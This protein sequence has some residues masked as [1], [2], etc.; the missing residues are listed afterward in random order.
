MQN[1]LKNFMEAFPLSTFWDH[2]IV[3]NTWANPH[4]ESFQDY[5]SEN[6]GTFL[7]KIL[8]CNN[9]IKIMAEKNITV[10]IK[11]K[12]YYVCSKKVKKYPEIAEEFNKIKNDIRTNSLMFKDIKVS[13]ILER[14]RES[15]KNEGFYIVT[16]YRTT[17]CID[18]KN[19]ETI[20]EEIIEENEVAPKNCKVIKT[21]EVSKY[22]GTDEVKLIDIV[23][24]GIARLI[25]N[26]EKY[27][28]YKVST[29]KVGD[30][31]IKGDEIYVRTEIR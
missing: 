9:L 6:P 8:L 24:L 7:E 18:F 26:V 5:M 15:Q 28:I 11:L 4:D 25:R 27:E 23:T 1:A 22:I 29:Y 19:K 12:E 3:V 30:K 20:I 16:K 14:S 21:E 17:T 13:P 31:E 10:P 2:V